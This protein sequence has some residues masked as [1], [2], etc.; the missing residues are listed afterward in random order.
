ML[1]E[2]RH[3]IILDL[4]NKNGLVAISD[5]IEVT[6]SSESTIRR[7]L[8][9]LEA[10][11]A[12][13]RVHGGAKL[14]EINS[15]ELTYSEK[16]SK[17]IQQKKAIAK[18]AASLIND[19]ECIFI[20]AGTSTFELIPEL[21]NRN[22]FVVTNGLKHIDSLIDNN[23]KCYM[24]GGNV[25]ATTRAVVGSMALKYLGNY[26]FDK[27]F[28]G[29]NG[30]DLEAGLTTP[31]TDEAIIKECAIKHSKKSYVLTDSSKFGQVSFVKFSDLNQC[32]IITNNCS[33]IKAYEKITNVKVADI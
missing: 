19:G 27:C 25:K 20:D 29:T 14:I 8:A 10:L 15:K 2:Q 18:L 13:Q 31:D 12:L 16:S 24:V 21:A 11:N 7:D 6:E 22:I 28:L 33:N 5:L 3:E 26:R 9:A 1:T 23:I 4:L 32:T 30:I 17:N